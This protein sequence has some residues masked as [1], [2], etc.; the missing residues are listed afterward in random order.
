[1]MKRLLLLISCVV[2]FT[3]VGA[4]KYYI[5]NQYVYDLYLMNP[6]AAGFYKGC[7][8][9]SGYYQKQW[10]GMEQAPT[11]QV[12]SFQG[13]LTQKLGIGSYFY[14]DRNGFYSELGLQASLSYEVM[15]IK[16]RKRTAS[17][18]FG[19]SLNVE[20]S[21]VDQGDLTEGAFDDPA[22]SGANESGWG[23]NG[24]AGML[25]KYNDYHLGFAVTNI[26][27]QNNKMYQNEYEPELTS[28][29]HLHA[30]TTYKIADRDI[31]LE[32][33]VMYRRNMQV[34]SKLDLTAKA[35]FPTPD[36][37]F[38]FWGLIAYRRTMDDQFGKSLGLGTTAGVQFNNI[39]VGLEF[40]AGLTGAQRDYG[41]A[42][43]LILKYRLCRD[44]SKGAI[45]CS[46]A[47]RLER[48]RPSKR[49]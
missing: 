17:M 48:S 15:L 18:T 30:G 43:Q 25:F 11:T 13:P 4:Q 37:D 33:L 47:S 16:D 9:F 21:A 40:Q 3:S 32:P 1:M 49:R 44:K 7:Y 42:Y 24:N 31:F 14:N 26:L 36:P 8:E 20:Q 38:S 28:D 19:M 35:T 34:N 29:I 10:F 12:L 6:A 5:T 23:F 46:E 27:P 2:A 41:S 45:P 22:L 39:I